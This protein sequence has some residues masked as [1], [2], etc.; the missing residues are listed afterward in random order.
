ML[1]KQNCLEWKSVPWQADEQFDNGGMLQ[2]Q[3]TETS[4]KSARHPLS[5]G[6]GSFRES[7]ADRTNPFAH[8]QHR[9][10]S[11]SLC[12]HPLVRLGAWDEQEYS[13]AR[14]F[15]SQSVHGI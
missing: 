9:S 13:E 2:H 1:H 5:K 8:V 4:P 6:K 14:E 7:S 11:E 15:F 3:L 12:F 10:F